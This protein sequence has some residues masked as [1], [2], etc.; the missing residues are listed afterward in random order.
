MG[1]AVRTL[2]IALL[3]ATTVAFILVGPATELAQASGAKKAKPYSLLFGTVWDS[4]GR[5]V[6]GA[7]VKIRREGQK[8]AKWHLVSDRRGEFAQ[9]LPSEAA[10][11]IVW[12]EGEGKAP[13]AETKVH[14]GDEAR[15]DIGLHLTE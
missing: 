7:R 3:M 9:R 8:N 10:D 4:S 13:L 2:C 12:V 5:P 6:Y 15:V 14:V 1:S 11:Y